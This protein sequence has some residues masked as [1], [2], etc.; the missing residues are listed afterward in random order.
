M[1]LPPMQIRDAQSGDAAG[2]AELLNEI[3]AIGG[4]TAHQSQMSAAVIAE[5]FV[6]GEGVKASVLA[7]EGDQIIGW[8]SLSLWQGEL[9]IGTFVHAGMQA[10]GIGSALFA[11]T[12]AAARATGLSHMIA[13]IRADNVPGLAYYTQIGFYD[14]GHD[15]DFALDD[16]TIAGRR[17]KRFDLV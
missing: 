3:I 6:N 13:H 2:M 5:Y 15:P 1:N 11:A 14:I 9:H 10:K 17:L 4:M 8:Q 16:G 12:C 7:E